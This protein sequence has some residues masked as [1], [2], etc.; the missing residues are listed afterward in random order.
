MK[1]LEE[2]IDALSRA[3]LSEARGEADQV[4]ADAQAKADAARQQAR[5]Q[6][7]RER[8]EILDRARQDAERI[9][10]QKIAAT[11]LKART[12]QLSSREKLLN[13]VYEKAVQE[14][15]TLQQWTDYEDIAKTLLR[16]AL[17]QL[18]ADEVL[19][20]G[21]PKTMSYFSDRFLDELAKEMNKKITRGEPLTRGIGV[22]VETTN[23]HMQ[24]DNTLE[25]RLQRMWN[26][27]R[28]P[29]HHLL[30]GEKL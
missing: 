7:E 16:E 20:R 4:L 5:E 29:I 3:V 10:G 26:T 12:M 13:K 18:R 30:M 15:P 24:Y 2:N 22:V 17:S 19:V 8:K 6:A 27:T 25:T 21:D 9:R 14:L 11:Q 28:A 1:S 23:G